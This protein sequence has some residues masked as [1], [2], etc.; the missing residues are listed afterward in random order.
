MIMIVVMIMIMVHRRSQGAPVDGGVGGRVAVDGLGQ[1]IKVLIVLRTQ[2]VV[3]TLQSAAIGS[4]TD[5]RLLLRVHRTLPLVI[6]LLLGLRLHLLLVGIGALLVKPLQV[7]RIRI[8]LGEGVLAQVEI[9]V[10]DFAVAGL[11]D[12]LAATAWTGTVGV[13]ELAALGAF[14]DVLRTGSLRR[15]QQQEGDTQKTRSCRRGFHLV[16]HSALFAYTMRNENVD[17]D[18]GRGPESG[19][20]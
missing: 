9:L 17:E 18:R 14:V 19:G 2:R 1:L 15:R 20:I 10:D 4:F 8:T 6:G 5:L 12:Q 16:R 13:F 7:M 3:L 11:V